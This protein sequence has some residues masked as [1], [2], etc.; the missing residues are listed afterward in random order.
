[1]I[2]MGKKFKVI[3]IIFILFFSLLLI[4]NFKN[5]FNKPVGVEIDKNVAQ[6]T[7]FSGE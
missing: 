2:F 6:E 4:N 7:Y 1:M 3:L 5:L